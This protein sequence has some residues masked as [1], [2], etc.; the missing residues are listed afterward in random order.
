MYDLTFA[1]HHGDPSR[2]RFAAGTGLFLSG[3]LFLDYRGSI[4]WKMNAGMG[5]VL[6]APLYQAL[7]ARGVDF[8]FFTRVDSLGLDADGGLDRDD[9]DRPSGRRPGRA[10]RLRPAGRL[11]RSSLLP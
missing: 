4:F 5:D 10:G 9:R 3:K 1:N 6:F 7:V 2:P 11:R 8:E